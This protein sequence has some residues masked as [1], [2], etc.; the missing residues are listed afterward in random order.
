[1]STR[2]LLATLA[3]L[4]TTGQAMSVRET[5]HSLANLLASGS[6]QGMVRFVNLSLKL[7]LDIA[8]RLPMP[9]KQHGNL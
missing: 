1:M 7:S 9:H 8:I 3:L 2:T 5:R 6:I 4:G